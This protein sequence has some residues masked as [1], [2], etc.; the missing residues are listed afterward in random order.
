MGN[1]SSKEPTTKTEREGDYI[2]TY[3]W[4][5]SPDGERWSDGVVGDVTGAYAGYY[6]TS[7]SSGWV[8]NSRTLARD[9]KLYQQGEGLW[10]EA[11]KLED[12]GETYQAQCKF[13]QAKEKFDESNSMYQTEKAK[14]FSLIASLKIQGNASFNEGDRLLKQA[15]DHLKEAYRLKELKRFHDAEQCLKKAKK[16]F[17]DAKDKF[18]QAYHLSNNDHRFK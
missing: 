16:E 11:W 4:E 3:T 14:N 12:K 7:Y 5:S 6:T 17:Q 13:N 15:I 2:C 10:C 8:C 18:R 1:S 9:V